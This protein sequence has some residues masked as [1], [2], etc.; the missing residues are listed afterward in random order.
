MKALIITGT[1]T[2]LFGA[3]IGFNGAWLLLA[4][5]TAFTAFKAITK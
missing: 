5:A 1:A 4:A 3:F 2:I